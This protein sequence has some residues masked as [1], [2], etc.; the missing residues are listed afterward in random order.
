VEIGRGRQANF[1][2][3]NGVARFAQFKCKTFER[4][5]GG[6]MPSREKQMS[7]SFKW[8]H[9]KKYFADAGKYFFAS[10]SFGSLSSFSLFS[11]TS[12]DAGDGL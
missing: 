5:D 4:G 1:R 12:A 2:F 6:E 7:C 8:M 9:A 3:F 10:Q 11:T